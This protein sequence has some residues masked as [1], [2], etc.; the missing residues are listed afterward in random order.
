[1]INREYDK[2]IILC[3]PEGAGGNFLINCLS[4]SDQCVLRDA[5][6]AEQQLI[7]GT[8]AKEK[9]DY[10]QTQIDISK[11]TN[12]WN[13]LGL[14]CDNLFGVES[15]SYL[16]SY[17]EIIE[18]KF[19][20]VI[21][22]LINQQKY[23]FIVAHST[24]YFNACYEF[25]PNAR[26]IFLTDYHDF[27]QQRN[28]LGAENKTKLTD[29]WNTVKG[30]DWPIA[31]PT[32]NKEFML[33]PH[34][35]QK[36]LIDNFHGEIFR[37]VDSSVLQEELHNRAVDQLIEHMGENAFVWNVDHAFNGD[38]QAFIKALEQCA[39]WA[40]IQ[41][42]ATEEDILRYYRNWLEVIFS[43]KQ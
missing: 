12:R 13:D 32:T 18:K 2:I 9:L 11:R 29:Y 22:Q 43:I 21:P 30:P 16:E 25:W 28:Y 19:N 37:W 36:E 3:Y 24:Q 8:S 31:P 6:L 34:A 20:Y 39:D 23:L 41:I 38:Q 27:V 17:P 1:M 35:I 40:G 10:F 15:L 42:S 33:L 7:V 4:L 5:K 14:G 26:A